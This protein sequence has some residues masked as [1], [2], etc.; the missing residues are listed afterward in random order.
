MTSTCVMKLRSGKGKCFNRNINFVSHKFC[1]SIPSFFHSEHDGKTPEI[2]IDLKE[3]P[4]MLL[5]KDKIGIILGGN[6]DRYNKMM[7]TFLENISMA[8]VKLVFFMP[9]H[10]Y[11]DDLQFL[12]PKT[13][14]I[15]NNSLEILDTIDENS[16]LR[17]YLREK[18]LHDH[19]RMELS[20]DYNLKKLVSNFGHF[21]VTHEQHNQEIAR[22]ANK[23]ADRVLALITNQNDFLAFSGGKYEYWRATSIDPT[24]MTCHRYNKKKLFDKLGFVGIV[25]MQLFSALCRSIFL[26]K[27]AIEHFLDR[28]AEENANPLQCGMIWNVSGYVKDQHISTVNDEMPY[29]LDLISRDVFGEDYSREQLDTI[30]KGLAYYKLKFELT[31][32]PELNAFLQHCKHENLFAYKLATDDIFNVKDISYIDFRNYKST[33]YAELVIPILMK[34]CGV[35]FKDDEHRP[36]ERK[37]CM[38]HA[39]DELLKMTDETIMYPS[40]K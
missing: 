25:Q 29:D 34:M 27:Y 13:E 33:S 18:K 37:I 28:L 16:D 8:G 31:P 32:C 38:K 6:Y 14:E 30:A 21:Y 19:M 2:L 11:S 23:N 22:Y 39:H 1:N 15:Y 5:Q 35:L 17:A 20:F 24:G 9:G 40:S 7:R 26:P 12:I 3:F 4:R 10:Q 36:T